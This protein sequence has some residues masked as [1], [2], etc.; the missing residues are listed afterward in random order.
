MQKNSI[1]PLIG[2]L[3]RLLQTMYTYF[4]SSLKRHLEHGTLAKLLETKGL[5][6]LHNVKLWW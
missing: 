6:L 2:K 4:L 1:Q 3:E 5:Q